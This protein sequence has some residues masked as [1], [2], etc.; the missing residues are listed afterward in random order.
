MSE[1]FA[2]KQNVIDSVII[3]ANNFVQI[4]KTKF[5]ITSINKWD[6]FINDL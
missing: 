1:K 2:F 5:P 6:R 3:I 4:Y